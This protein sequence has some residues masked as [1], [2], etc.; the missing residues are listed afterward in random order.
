MADITFRPIYASVVEDADEN[1]LSIGFAEGEDE[2][3]PYLLFQQPMNGGPIW[4]EAGDAS[5]GGEDVVETIQLT[6][7]GLGIIIRDAA[8][9]RTGWAREIAVNI[10]PACE[11]ADEAITALRAMFGPAFQG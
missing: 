3:E 1:L 5:L 10:S 2:D 9:A 11:S 8:L 6:P 4:F 7:K